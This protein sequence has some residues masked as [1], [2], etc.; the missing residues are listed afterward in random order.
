MVRVGEK[1]LRTTVRN[2]A[3]TTP[4]KHRSTNMGVFEAQT[5]RSTCGGTAAADDTITPETCWPV[6][7]I[8]LAFDVEELTSTARLI[9]GTMKSVFDDLAQYMTQLI[10]IPNHTSNLPST[11]GAFPV[12]RRYQS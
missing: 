11:N 1:A 3:D 12:A 4:T 6:C 9:H 10:S 2:L 7:G 8:A 5:I